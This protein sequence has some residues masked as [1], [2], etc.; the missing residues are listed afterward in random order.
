MQL[1]LESDIANQN[2]VG[3]KNPD[4]ALHV[5]FYTK[6]CKN[7]W[8]TTK[9]GRPIFE[10]KVY[11]R[12][13][14]PGN[15][16]SVIDVPARDDHK[17]RFPLHWAHFE[18]THGKTEGQIGTPVN[19]WAILSPA[20][21]EMLRALKFYTVEQIA[22]A[23]DDQIN[24]CGMLAGMAPFAFR[25]RAKMYLSGAK[26]DSE[27][28]KLAAELQ[29]ERDARKALEERLARLE[30]GQPAPV[31]VAAAPVSDAAPSEAKLGTLEAAERIERSQLEMTYEAK[32]GRKPHPNMGLDK[33]RA[34]AASEA[35]TV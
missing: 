16:L 33:L 12:I 30:A 29:A 24:S 7:D 32:Y 27:Q 15:Q 1:G 25:D 14:T 23:S 19:Q 13:H 26:G 9:Q 22:F 21:V 31:V 20:Q 34:A 17:A 35:Q 5:V 11:V 10:D 18:N 2:F 6:P 4:T 3:A 8:E 28:A